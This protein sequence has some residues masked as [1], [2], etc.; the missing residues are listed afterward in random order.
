[1]KSNAEIAKGLVGSASSGKGDSK[2]ADDKDGKS[3]EGNAS[4]DGLAAAIKD[5][6]KHM[7]NKDWEGAAQA[8]RNAHT[9]AMADQGKD[10]SDSGNEY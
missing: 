1:M 8:W 10:D 2:S 9:I 7:A 3:P 4:P 5:I 6:D